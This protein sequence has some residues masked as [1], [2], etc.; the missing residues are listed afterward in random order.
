MEILFN[1]KNIYKYFD[2]NLSKENNK[3]D[4][5]E[6]FIT[7]E[8]R[9][10]LISKRKKFIHNYRIKQRIKFILEKNNNNS[11][12][13]IN[14]SDKFLTIN[15]IV[16]EQDPISRIILL[17]QYIQNKPLIIDKIFLKNNLNILKSF[18]FDFKKILNDHNINNLNNKIIVYRYILYCC[19]YLLYEPE[20]NPLISE[21]DYEF[22]SDLN[23]FFNYY[24]NIENNCIIKENIFK[25][26]LYIL[27]L[28]NNLIR[29]HPDVELL[30]AIFDLK[31][32]IFF[33]YNK[34]FYFTKNNDFD[35]NNIKIENDNNNLINLNEC[36]DIS[37][38]F[39]LTF[40]KLIE[41]CILSL[42]LNDND[43]KELIDIIIN[44]IYYNYSFEHIQLLIYSLET[45]VNA[46]HG[47]LLLDNYK[48]NNFLLSALEQITISYN[49]ND[50]NNH[51][52]LY[53]EKNKYIFEL[54]LQQ[55]LFYLS[56]DTNIIKSNI[57][58][59]LYLK[60]KIIIF[61]KNYYYQFYKNITT[62]YK[63]E[64]NKDELKL[65][66]KIT[67]IFNVYFDLINSLDIISITLEQKNN[68]KLV[69][70]SNFSKR[71]NM[72]LSL[73]EVLINLFSFFIG[74]DVKEYKKLC[75]LIINIFINIYPLKNI[76]YKNDI[77]YI[78][79]TKLFLIEK[80]S[81]HIKIFPY[82]NYEND[83][84]SFLIKD[85]LELINGVLFFCQQFDN[86]EKEKMILK[87]IKKDICDYNIL[88]EI[89]KIEN[90]L[91]NTDIYCYSKQ[92]I[93]N[94][95]SDEK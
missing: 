39:V 74:T 3:I 13:I 90:N 19:I 8:R 92:I 42:Y 87:K 58:L 7:N 43:K 94:Y 28:L 95:F 67:K 69:L 38:L 63:K 5:L 84:Y 2:D 79:G 53:L 44:L 46:N 56:I 71:D 65:I 78:K 59:N 52:N 33:I 12:S 49:N 47:F 18:F 88:E 25:L 66:V 26:H 86:Y 30:K 41:N 34:Y 80:C 60:E 20:L 31:K 61:F 48:Y 24:L 27:I 10:Q 75:Y 57:N 54:Y 91:V 55:L 45:L 70:S 15:E 51:N 72:E 9:Y 73:F 93:D 82:L 11:K 21:F 35:I 83:D 81:L 40:L 50:T 1:N 89:E 85:I 14:N 32:I 76:K 77:E 62:N 29:I 17:K 22:L 4:S 36:G 6:D 37:E 16:K 23:N 64:I 68:F